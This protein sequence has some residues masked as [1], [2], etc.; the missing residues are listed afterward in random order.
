MTAKPST[1]DG[2]PDWSQNIRDNPDFVP[3]SSK[4]QSRKV[5]ARRTSVRRMSRGRRSSSCVQISESELN[6]LR[7]V[8]KARMV[9]ILMV[10]TGYCEREILAQYDSFQKMCPE[11]SLSKKMFIQVS[12]KLY[13]DNAKNL[14]EAI[15]DIFDEDGSGRIDFVEY[16][17]A[18][19]SSNMNTPEMKLNWIFNVFDKVY[20]FH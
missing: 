2:S 9:N 3:L 1:A 7:E 13:G 14:S 4:E 10:K 18:I 17:M 19:N 15:F 6:K 16:M 20:L 5:V 12:R 8:E 11:G